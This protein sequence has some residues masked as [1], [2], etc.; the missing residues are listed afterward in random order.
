MVNEQSVFQ[1]LR[2]DSTNTFFHDHLCR[3]QLIQK[4]WYTWE[5]LAISAKGDKYCDF[6]FA[7]QQNKSLLCFAKIALCKYTTKMLLRKGWMQD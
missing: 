4:N 2:F 7:F 1:L 3:Q 6:L 5:I